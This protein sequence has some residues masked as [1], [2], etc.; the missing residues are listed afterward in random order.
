MFS[1][2]LQVQEQLGNDIAE[3]LQEVLN[4]EG[5]GVVI[6]A[7]HMCMSMRGASLSG[8][9]TVTTSLRGSYLEDKEVRQEFLAMI[10]K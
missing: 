7:S 5:L 4:P 10:R 3:C 2:R 1:T 9:E 8:S 6:K